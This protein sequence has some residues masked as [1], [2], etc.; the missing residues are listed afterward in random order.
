MIREWTSFFVTVFC[1][2][3]TY[4][5]YLLYASPASYSSLIRNPGTIFFNVIALAFTLYHAA[6]WF[7]LTGRVQPIKIGKTTTKPWQALIVNV[8]LLLVLFYVVIMLFGL[9]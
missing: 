9:K 8:V 6:T 1:L 3:Y 7:Y 4:E 2:V 5:I